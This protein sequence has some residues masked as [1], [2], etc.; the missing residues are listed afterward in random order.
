MPLINTILKKN[1]LIGIRRVPTYVVTSSA[2]TVNEITPITY[3]IRTKWI[4]SGTVL[5]YTLSGT[6]I[7][8]ADI[9]GGVLASSITIIDNLA[10]LVV[11]PLQDGVFTEGTETLVFDLRTGSTSGPIVATRSVNITDTQLI[12]FD[13]LLVGGGG[14]GGYDQ[15]GGGGGGQVRST[16]V[17]LIQSQAYSLT[18]SVAGPTGA[19]GTG[20]STTI[21]GA[22]FTTLTA[23]GGGAGGSRRSGGGGGGNG[24]GGGGQDNQGGTIPGAASTATPAGFTGGNGGQWSG[25]GGAGAAANGG[26]GGGN[27]AGGGA[28]IGTLVSWAASYGGTSSSNTG[29]TGGYFG[30]GG[31]GGSYHPTVASVLTNSAGGGGGNGYS[32]SYTT[33]RPPAGD[34]KANTGGGGGGGIGEGTSFGGGGGGGSGFVLVRYLGSSKGSGGNSITSDGTYTYHIFTSSGTLSITA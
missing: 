20:S 9:T 32:G 2:N 34:A 22:S 21:S 16:T 25:G 8:A 11:S 23:I 30:G 13:F 4:R 6:N 28:G 33:G 24:G 17:S 7:T 12:S 26:G 10:T 14:G 18:V 31:R 19:S 3:T 29:T 1:N 27:G 5:Y 15:G